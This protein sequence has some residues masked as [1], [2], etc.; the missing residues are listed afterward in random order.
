MPRGL[1]FE[2]AFRLLIGSIL[3]LAFSRGMF[4]LPTLSSLRRLPNFGDVLRLTT[5]GDVL[6]RPPYH[7]ESAGRHAD[8]DESGNEAHDRC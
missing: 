3:R 6:R 7:P 1:P 4:S 5:F 8:R 2:T